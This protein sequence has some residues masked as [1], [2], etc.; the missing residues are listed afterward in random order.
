M[1]KGSFAFVCC[2][3]G[4]VARLETVLGIGN[5]D[6]SDVCIFGTEF[7]NGHEPSSS[8][9][10]GHL[11][12]VACVD[13]CAIV[14]VAF[15]ARAFSSHELTIQDLPEH[16]AHMRVGARNTI[17]FLLLQHVQEFVRGIK[18][19]EFVEANRFDH[20]LFFLAVHRFGKVELGC[21]RLFGLVSL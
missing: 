10:R 6:E 13:H 14:L 11:Y 5:A 1:N 3:A 18:V 8:T 7:V 16:D 19:L 21:R 20:L 2:S 9:V 15:L 17:L 12:H 4:M